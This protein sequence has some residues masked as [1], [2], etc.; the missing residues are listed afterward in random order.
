ML[1]RGFKY[2]DLSSHGAA[3]PCRCEIWQ[4]TSCGLFI[5]LL[6]TIDASR[7]HHMYRATAPHSHLLLR[8]SLTSLL[9][10]LSPYRYKSQ[11]LVPTVG[12]VVGLVK[13]GECQRHF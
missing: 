8:A 3:Y 6:I 10:G 4:N 5:S 11:S 12:Q 7:V 13:L 2:A 1:L 9:N